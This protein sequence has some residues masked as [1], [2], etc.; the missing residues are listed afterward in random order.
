MS[1]VEGVGGVLYV[2]ATPIGHLDDITIRALEVLRGVDRI[3][4]ED[5]RHTARLLRRHRLSTPCV[6]L[7]EHNERRMVERL[8]GEIA[9]GARL[10]L[11][12]DAGTP[13]LSD[14]GFALVRALREAGARIV[15]IPGPSALTCA[16]SVAGLPTDRVCFEGFLPSRASA[17]RARLGELV[18]EPRTLVFFEAPH[19][20]SATVRDMCAAF[21]QDRP[22]VLA[23]ELTKMHEQVVAAGLGALAGKLED[24]AVP[25]RGE[26]VVVVGGASDTAGAAA[27]A[28]EPGRVLELLL[29]ELPPARAA[30]LAARL[31]GARR[32]DLYRAALG[33]GEAARGHD[34]DHRG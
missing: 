2:V 28:P 7:H 20:V 26:F 18:R 14:P 13:L 34:D 23:R 4:A 31:T 25:S 1:D 19:R 10:A 30:R 27:G 11:V 15:P 12:S 3:L 33:A 9:A 5:T 17:R 22:A 24:Q 16:L 8:V 29:Q 32:A 21:G 6:A